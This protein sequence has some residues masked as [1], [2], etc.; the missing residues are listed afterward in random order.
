MVDLLN[1]PTPAL[2]TGPRSSPARQIFN[3]LTRPYPFLDDCA[4]KFGD[5][6][7]LRFWGLEP[8]V[9]CSNPKVIQSIFR[10]GPN[11]FT[12]GSSNKIARP[13][14]GDASI[15]LLDGDRHR[16]QRQLLMPPFHGER[17]R[18]YSATIYDITARVSQSWSQGD[19]VPVRPVI[20]DISLR[21]ILEA[22]FGLHEG[23]AL[24][25]LATLTS[26]ML[27]TTSSPLSSSML[28]LPGLQ[29]DLG[30]WSPW[31]Q[32]LQRR[33]QIDKIL[34][35]QIEARRRAIE[36]GQQSNDILSMLLEARDEAGNPMTDSELR[37]EL[38][39]L[40]VAGHETTASSLAWALYWL[41]RDPQ[42]LSTLR[43][44]LATVDVDATGDPMT[45]MRLPYL[46][47]VCQEAL[48]LYPV[49]PITFPRR[50]ME[51]PFEFEGHLLPV[52]SLVAPCPYLTHQ[53][54]DLY[55][56]P[57]RFRPERF[58]EREFSAYEFITF[59]GGNRQCIGM[60]F[61][62]FEMKIVLATLLQRYEFTLAQ[63]QDIKPVRRGLT[64]APPPF[65]LTVAQR[66]EGRLKRHGQ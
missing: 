58:L 61:A 39:T 30:A 26:E 45:L 56:E 29:R 20:Q 16:R 22:V 40:L 35:Q 18:T 19:R 49:V 65:Q 7:T 13:L 14:V 32:F 1:R 21:V 34:Y 36:A 10:A 6:F 3:W 27:D 57:K 66:L 33:S 31:G 24:E 41:H 4:Q 11:R 55:P 28:F 46:N 60:A 23:D 12:A 59:G 51:Q 37:D 17:M 38:I 5:T 25:R 48:R 52:D 47:A 2:P 9:F 15:L 42:I 62:L 54:P 8:I 64:V 50:V 53:R 44:E 63:A 43:N